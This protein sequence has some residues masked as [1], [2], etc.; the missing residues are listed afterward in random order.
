MN[1][2]NVYDKIVFEINC[3]ISKIQK[4]LD[5]QKENLHIESKST[6]GDKHNTS[7]AMMHIEIDKLSQQLSKLIQIN[8]LIQSVKPEKC[9]DKIQPGSLVET[10]F[11]Y[12]Y[13]IAPL[14]NISFK[15]KKIMV[16]SLASPIGKAL[17]DKTQGEFITLYGNRWEIKKIT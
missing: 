5:N 10:N 16:I 17:Q 13:I 7:R 2:K 8:K 3:R 1:K 6:A 14:G 15:G 4:A 11:G 12:L 9:N